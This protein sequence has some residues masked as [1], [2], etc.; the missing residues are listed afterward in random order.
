VK[1]N[2][3]DLNSPHFH[4]SQRERVDDLGDDA[5][6]DDDDDDGD[7]IAGKEIKAGKK[8]GSIAKNARKELEEKTGRSVVTDQNF[9]KPKKKK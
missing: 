2:Y 4:S 7:A 3:R 6:D 5:E 8:G 1:E 9:L